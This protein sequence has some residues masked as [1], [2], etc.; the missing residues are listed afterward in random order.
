M[1]AVLVIPRANHKGNDGV[2][3]ARDVFARIPQVMLTC[4]T[5]YV[6]CPPHR[7]ICRLHSFV[8]LHR[9][10]A[11][12]NEHERHYFDA[13]AGVTL[14]VT[15][16]GSSGLPQRQILTLV[17]SCST[18]I[19][20]LNPEIKGGDNLDDDDRVNMRPYLY[21]WDLRRNVW[22]DV[23]PTRD[24]VMSGGLLELVREF[25]VSIYI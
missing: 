3:L 22:K 6:W 17:I 23:G 8:P 13:T 9:C 19:F 12:V 5:L 4:Y 15:A 7:L 20:R 21:Q 16:Y 14:Y 18:G 10:R 2:L 1:Y 11:Y 24:L 25:N